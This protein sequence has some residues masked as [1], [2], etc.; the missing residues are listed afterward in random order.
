[1]QLHTERLILR[2]WRERPGLEELVRVLGAERGEARFVGGCVRDTLLG[3]PV[4][5]VDV[6]TRHEPPAPCRRGSRTGRSPR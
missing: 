6:A 1:M 4:A 3:C 5:D 2:P